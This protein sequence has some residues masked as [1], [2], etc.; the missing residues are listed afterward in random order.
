MDFR[1]KVKRTV[2]VLTVVGLTSVG[3][4]AFAE[5]PVLKAKKLTNSVNPVRLNNRVNNPVDNATTSQ[6]TDADKC[7]EKTPGGGAGEVSGGM[8]HYKPRPAGGCSDWGSDCSPST[9]RGEETCACLPKGFTSGGLP[10]P[11]Q[12]QGLGD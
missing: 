2:V 10:D 8:C 7:P 11:G 6:A 5:G 1:N 3:M 9:L 4:G 12:V